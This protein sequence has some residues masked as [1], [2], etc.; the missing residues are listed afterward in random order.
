MRS[1][2]VSTRLRDAI[3]T[4]GH[5]RYRLSRETGVTEST[6]SRFMAG[7]SGL[8]LEAVDALSA[9]LGLELVPLIP[10]ERAK[11]SSRARRAGDAKP[12]RRGG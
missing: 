11:A 6:L 5:S 4:C 12:R 10:P 7:K 8:N 3:D 9:F 1:T 2:P